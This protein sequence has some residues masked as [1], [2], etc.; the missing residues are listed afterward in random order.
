MGSEHIAVSMCWSHEKRAQSIETSCFTLTVAAAAARTDKRLRF[1]GRRQHEGLLEAGVFLLHA[2][3][4][5]ILQQ[6][7]KQKQP[8]HIYI[9]REQW[10]I[11]HVFIASWEIHVRDSSE[12]KELQ[13]SMSKL[14]L[15]TFSSLNLSC[16]SIIVPAGLPHSVSPP[17]CSLH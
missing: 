11:R 8:P 10:K 16:H 5:E 13:S 9:A 3:H 7:N 6:T 2:C 12:S 1:P 17:L 4:F 15:R 14:P